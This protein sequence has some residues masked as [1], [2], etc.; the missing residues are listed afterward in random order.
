MEDN[1]ES[2]L[3]G[4]PNIIPYECTKKVIQQMEKN[5]CKIKTDKDQGTGFFCKI[6]FPDM[7]NMLPVIITNYHII[8]EKILE[9]GQLNIKIKEEKKSRIMNLNNRIKFTNKDYD[10]TIIELKDNDDINNYLELDDN[11]MNDI[12][13]NDDLNEDYVDKTI[14]II[15]Y[16]EGELSV[17]YGVLDKIFV[18]KKYNFNHKCCTRRGSSGSPIL[19][20]NN[21]IIG[22]HK[23]AYNNQY[24]KGLFLNYPI[25]EFV[26]LHSKTNKSLF[27]PII[28]IQNN[29]VNRDNNID[30]DVQ[31]ENI[32]INNLSNKINLIDEQF[33]S[34]TLKFNLNSDIIETEKGQDK[35]KNINFFV[36]N[37][38][39]E[40]LSF[41]LPLN[42]SVLDLKKRIAERIEFT[43]K[44]DEE[45]LIL[46]GRNMEDSKTLEFYN[47]QENQII[48]RLL[49]LNG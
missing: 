33:T 11:I 21:K 12:L 9:K 48:Y 8:D 19:G 41:N 44:I 17:S 16:P 18:D 43:I 7:N 28:K 24:N 6:P 36:R 2:I 49:R 32:F 46:N 40:N 22:L 27:Q 42:T 14:Y 26:K 1:N 45:R 29:F 20:I 23:G 4:Y 3:L 31:N 37:I 15:Q 38:N 10:I 34:K 5:I 39:D 30:D 25:K 47:L 35:N 13:N